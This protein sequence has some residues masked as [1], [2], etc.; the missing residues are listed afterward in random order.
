MCFVLFF[1]WLKGFKQPLVLLHGVKTLTVVLRCQVSVSAR[2]GMLL[3]Y[4]RYF[5][6]DKILRGTTEWH[7]GLVSLV[8]AGWLAAALTETGYT[9][10]ESGPLKFGNY[11]RG[12]AIVAVT[13]YTKLSI[14]SCTWIQIINF[15]GFNFTMKNTE[16]TP[17]LKIPAI[18]YVTLQQH[19]RLVE[20]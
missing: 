10:K 12:N 5:S 4:S 19:N 16:M 9:K 1:Y 7:A 11:L 2:I 8:V 3:P 14:D 15:H 13:C 20:V 17:L 18:Q 6:W